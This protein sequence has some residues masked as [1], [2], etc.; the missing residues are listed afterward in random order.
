MTFV[1]R[2]QITNYKSIAT[3][4]V[5]LTPF[6]L[7]VGPNGSGKSN[8]VDALRLVTDSLQTIDRSRAARARVGAG[9]PAPLARSPHAFHDRP[10]AEPAPG[11]AG[12]LC[13]QDRTDS[14]RRLR[15]A[16]GEGPDPGASG[17]LRRQGRGGDPKLFRSASTDPF[18]QPV[19]HRR[20][21]LL[22][23]PGIVPGP[24]VHGLLQHQSNDRPGSS[25]SRRGQAAAP[26][27]EQPGERGCAGWSK[28]TRRRSN[29]Y[30][31]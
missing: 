1:E 31:D 12:P 25:G 27:R 11:R 3:C 6:T 4:D 22:R 21:R 28:R 14:E 8:F 10:M 20:Q 16:A 2:V 19:P 5:S 26:G 30:R 23:V 9:S 17:L 24:G 7:L 13:L 29:A 15:R 18:R